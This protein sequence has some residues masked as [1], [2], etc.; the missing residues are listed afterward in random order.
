MQRRERIG[1]PGT[2]SVK[3]Q[4]ARWRKRLTAALLV[5]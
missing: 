3:K 2:A 5:P 1:A 4:L